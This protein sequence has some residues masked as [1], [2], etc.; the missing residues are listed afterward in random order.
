MPADIIARGMASNSIKI[1]SS[2]TFTSD[3]ERDAYYLANPDSLYDGIYCVSG[4][5]LQKYYNGWQVVS[6]VIKGAKGDSGDN[7]TNVVG[8]EIDSNDDL[9]ITMSDATI[10][11]AGHLDIPSLTSQLTNDSGFLTSV[12]FGTNSTKGIVQADGVTTTITNGVISSLGGGG[13]T[14]DYNLL[15]NKPAIN[16]VSLIGN[17]TNED[18]GIIVPTTV[19]AFTNDSGYVTKTVSDLNNYTPSSNLSTVATSGEYNDLLNKPSI[20]TKTSDISNDNGYTTSSVS[21]LLNYTPTT[22]LSTVATSGQYNDLLNKPSIPVNTSDIINDSGYITNSTNSLANYQTTT[23]VNNLLSDKVDKIVGKGLSTNDYTTI[24]KTKLSGIQEGAEVNVQTDWL[25]I[26]GDALLLNKPTKLSEFENDSSFATT[27]NITDA[28]TTHNSNGSA[29]SSLFNAKLATSEANSLIKNVAFDSITGVLTFTKYD[30]TT[31]TIDLP[32]EEIVESGYYDEVEGE[33]VLVLKDGQEI[34][35]PAASL[36][37]DYTGSTTST[38]QVSIN[39]EN[40][41]SANIVGNGVTR[42]LLS[43]ELQNSLTTLESQTH[44]HSN[45]TILDNTTAS[46]TTTDKS[47]LDSNTTNRHWH[48]NKATLDNITSANLLDWN[49]DYNIKRLDDGS[50]FIAPSLRDA[51]TLEG[52]PS[53]YFEVATDYNLERNNDPTPYSGAEIRDIDRIKDKLGNII[54]P[55]TTEKAVYDEL[56][57]RLDVKLEQLNYATLFPTPLSNVSFL[58]NHGYE[59]NKEV[60]GGGQVVFSSGGLT[61]NNWT[62]FATISKPPATRLYFPFSVI[63]TT[64]GCLRIDPDGK[65]FCYNSNGTTV[66]NFTIYYCYS[67]E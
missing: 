10:I 31:Q 16:G 17:Q 40:V 9:I 55:I 21:D 25:A 37:G 24:E 2:N 3:V 50:S 19:S 6:A 65:M 47:N 39:E 56:G 4:E 35:I 13:G 14:S 48:T 28:I 66:T 32:T 60:K 53:N 15:I 54:Y 59:K 51:D 27:I 45:K 23:T 64:S 61:N 20:P 11:N 58:N 62:Q 49:D 29:H 12:P 44:T 1:T 38:I 63:G 7:G 18:L 52:L 43:V 42:N 34:R 8:A 67:I 41:I 33:L 26:S 22:S 30:N 46:F 36:V 57:T 5:D